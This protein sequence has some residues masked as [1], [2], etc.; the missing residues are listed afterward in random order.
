MAKISMQITVETEERADRWACRSPELGFIVY[1]KTY[2][3][4][5][6][7]V[8]KALTALLRSFHGDVEAIEHF[9]KKREVL[10][11]KIERDYGNGPDEVG[12]GIQGAAFRNREPSA[13]TSFVEILIA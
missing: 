1:G 10:H 6:Q 9:L 12:P 4:A 11:Y 2:E 13:E 7:E 5:R 8:D 3:A